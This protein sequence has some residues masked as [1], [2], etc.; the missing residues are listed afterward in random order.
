MRTR[1]HRLCAHLVCAVPVQRH[2]RKRIL[3]DCDAGINALYCG[4]C[5]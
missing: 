5:L 4:V 2:S 3:H 1:F